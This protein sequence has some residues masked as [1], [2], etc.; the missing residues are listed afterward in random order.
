MKTIVTLNI[1]G[2]RSGIQKGFIE[3]LESV[4]ADIVCLQEIKANEEQIPIF[5]LTALGYQTFWFSAMKKGYSGTAI[6]TKH[7]PDKIIK[8]MGIDKYDNEGRLIRMD[9]GNITYL[10]VYHPSG[11][12][13]DSRQ[14]FK[15]QWLYDFYEY[16]HKLKKERPHLVISGDF[17]ICH[18]EIDIHD[19]IS[20]KKSSG[21]LPEERAWMDKFFNSGFIDTFRVVNSEPHQYTWWSFRA[22][23]REKN[24]G[25]RID[26][27]VVTE[28]LKERITEAYIDPSV[29]LSDHCP[30]FLVIE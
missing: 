1:N 2:I 29:K 21:F 26:Y 9:I 24:L 23:A 25:W 17:N 11:S 16:I 14:D 8:G 27:N 13:S 18:K 7:T 20:N 3:Y 15:M 12:S 28:N 30:V 10:S 22:N 5:E 4:Q 19:P 6:L